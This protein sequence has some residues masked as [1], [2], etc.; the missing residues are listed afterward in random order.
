MSHLAPSSTD[1]PAQLEEN[2]PPR[3]LLIGWKE[4]L[5]LP[6]LGIFR[7][8]AKIDTGARTSTLHVD[9][10]AV[11]EKLPD[12]TELAELVLAPDRRHPDRQLATRVRLLRRISVTDSGG[13]PE[14]RPL[15]ETELVLG[16]LRK[17]I[18]VTLTDRSAMLFRMI[19]GRTALTG[20]FRIDAGEK[21]LLRSWH[22]K[23]RRRR[24]RDR[25]E[26]RWTPR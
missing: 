2:D 3:P 9:S 21:Y 19:V 13:R 12:G 8:K 26:E 18:L 23:R 16:P 5:D 4:Y 14:V 15:I 24:T 1:L 25:P 11:V 7:L 6:D 17:P 10:L 22:P 20:D